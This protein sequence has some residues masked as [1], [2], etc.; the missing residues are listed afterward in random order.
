MGA[1]RPCARGSLRSEAAR[2]QFSCQ[3]PGTQRNHAPTVVACGVMGD[4]ETALFSDDI[5]CD[6]LDSHFD[7]VGDG[8]TGPEATKAL[9]RE[10]SASLSDPDVS[11]VFWLAL[12]ATQ[13]RCG[14]LES[15]VLQEA[16]KVIDGGS[17]L[18]RSESDSKD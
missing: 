3:Q 2:S 10:W 17:D 5:A 4:W 9:L 11:P 12:A 6:V 14:R 8:L 7:F 13:W 1:A 15:H 16:L 18:A